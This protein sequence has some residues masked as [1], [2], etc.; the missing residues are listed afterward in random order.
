MYASGQGRWLS[1]DP[2]RACP[3]HP[4]NF[5]RYAYVG[6]SPTNRI[7]PR[8][9]VIVPTNYYAFDFGFGHNPFGYDEFDYLDEFGFVPA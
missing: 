9:D 4:Q 6:N 7:D 5:D 1:P 2:V 3:L 8:G